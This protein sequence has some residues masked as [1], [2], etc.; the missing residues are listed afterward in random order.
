[1][2]LS[3]CSNKKS[4]DI[5]LAT[6]TS[7]YD[8]GLLDEL[9]P[10]FTKQYGYKVKPIAV[11]TGEALTMGESGEADILLVHAPAAEKAFMAAGYGLSRKKVMY[12]WFLL[13]GPEKD[14][15]AAAE[16]DNIAEA[17][18]GISENKAAFISRGDDSGTHKKELSLWKASK[19]TPDE[20][21]Y[22]EA[23][24]GMGA[25]LR[26]ADEKQGYTLTDEGTFRAQQKSLS[27]R[28]FDF[29][30]QDLKNNYSVIVVTKTPGSEAFSRFLVSRRGQSLIRKFRSPEYK[31]PLFTPDA[32]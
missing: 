23:G 9:I 6:T 18:Q 2:L 26:I 12:N 28:A 30:D 1:M 21:W 19:K 14:I 16:T 31:K 8:T 29:A 25:T 20:P 11:G 13:V 22:Q 15:A 5:I 7:T 32:K 27:L 10:V 4:S 24:Q 17:F 3:G